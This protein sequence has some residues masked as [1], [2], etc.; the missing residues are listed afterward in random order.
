MRSVRGQSSGSIGTHPHGDRHFSVKVHRHVS[1]SNVL[2][3]TS[4]KHRWL[5]MSTSIE[6]HCCIQ[7][8]VVN[9]GVGKSVRY[10]DHFRIPVAN[11]F[12]PLA[13]A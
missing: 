3:A 5:Y 13:M 9:L 7:S 11:V 10:L 1:I 6:Y 2:M 8:C 4:L 12:W